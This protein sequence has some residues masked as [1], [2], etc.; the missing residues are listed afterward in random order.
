M[1]ERASSTDPGL[2]REEIR[3]AAELD[4]TIA[5]SDQTGSDLDQTTS[6]A[7]Q[8]ASERDQI[9]S[10]RDQQAADDDQAVSDRTRGEG[11]D[12]V[13]YERSRLA[14]SESSMERDLTAHARSVTA[15]VRDDAA[16]QRDRL[17]DERDHAAR[18]RDALAASLDAEIER[19]DVTPSENGRRVT[20]MDILVR[21]AADRRRAAEARARSAEQREQA[22]ADR[23]RAAQ[24]RR[25]AALDR[26]AAA[27]EIALEG[28]DHL[29][30]ALRRRAGLAAIQ[31]EM[32]RTRRS[33]QSLVVA[34]VDLDGLKAAND[35]RGHAAGDELLQEVARCTRQHL[36][37]YDVIARYGGDEFLCSL[38]GLDAAGAHARFNEIAAALAASPHPATITV[39]LAVSQSEDCLDDLIHRADAAMLEARKGSA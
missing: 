34:F 39:G 1:T 5:D 13:G 30:G 27:E 28:I 21:A 8:S 2:P 15:R 14:R 18:A 9:A 10:D 36:R 4:Q 26:A 25:Q 6:D 29:T 11:P 23:E 35:T 24:D 22:A 33:G 17:A 12:A 37:S 31:C 20:G 32:D 16:A 7:D 38:S 3:A 19:L